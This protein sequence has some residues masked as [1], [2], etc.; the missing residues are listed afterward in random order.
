M[1]EKKEDGWSKVSSNTKKTKKEKRWGT[2]YKLPYEIQRKNP[3]SLEN[4]NSP[5]IL[6]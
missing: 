1:N 2:L 5:T 4:T 6:E 3:R